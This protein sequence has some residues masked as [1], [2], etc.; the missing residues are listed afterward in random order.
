MRVLIAGAGVAGL[1]LAR[2]LHARGI[3][4][5]VVERTTA[6]QHGGAGLYLPGNALRALRELG[7]ESVVV[8]HANPIG[9][10]RIL[11]HRGRLLADID[12]ERFW[13][14][15][16][17][18]VA[19]HR[20]ALHEALLDATADVP[21]RLGT[22]VTAVEDGDAPRVTFSDGSTS[23]YDVVVGADGVHSTIR[24]LVLGGPPSRQVGQASW[25]FLADG[26]PEISD[27]TAMLGRGRT[28]LTV[29]LGQGVVYCYAD[30]STSD[31]EAA[32]GEDWRAS[33][34]DFGE[35]VSRLLAQADEA[36]FAPIEEVVPP[37]W[38]AGRVALVGDA[39]HASSPNMAQGAAMAVEDAL[40]LADTLSA[41]RPV[42]QALAAYEQRRRVRVAW[43]QEQTHRRDRTRS[44]PAV[45]RNITLR[46]AGERIFRSNYRPLLDL[47]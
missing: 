41:G 38:T 47:P 14:G 37:T 24:S 30:I 2:A 5:D 44:L 39:A 7:V 42:E 22:S 13:H 21:I 12:V 40:V 4:A 11:D 45:V 19:I 17:P 3:T 46:L 35:P 9:R 33:F 32:A 43:V 6:W 10:Q 28:F 20:A 8:A 34:S 1:A 36:Y 26:F 29:A 16:G 31:P 25:R 27:W 23:S 18:C 15:V